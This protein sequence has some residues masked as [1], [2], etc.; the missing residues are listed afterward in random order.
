MFSAQWSF[1]LYATEDEE[2]AG[3]PVLYITISDWQYKMFLK[4]KYWKKFKSSPGD[5]LVNW[6]IREVE[7]R[8]HGFIKRYENMI[9]Y[10]NHPVIA[11]N[12]GHD[13]KTLLRLDLS[14]S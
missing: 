12:Q 13:I 6:I 1:I 2:K 10:L 8:I 9:F 4:K 3:I 7:K 14:S 11:I 5:A